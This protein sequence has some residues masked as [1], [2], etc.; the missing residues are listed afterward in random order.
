M[1]DL[2]FLNAENGFIQ[3]HDMVYRT[4]NGVDFEPYQ[5]ILDGIPTSDSI[6]YQ[7]V[8]VGFQFNGPIGVLRASYT[9][10]PQTQPWITRLWR[11]TDFGVTWIELNAMAP[12][13]IFNFLDE[14]HWFAADM[15]YYETMDGGETWDTCGVYLFSFPPYNGDCFKILDE[16]GRGLISMAYHFDF[17][18][19]MGCDQPI[20]ETTVLQ[21]VV[22]FDIQETYS[23]FLRF[24]DN[25][26]VVRTSID[27]GQT[28]L[29]GSE[30]LSGAWSIHFINDDRGWACGDDGKIWK[31]VSEGTSITEEA[32]LLQGVVLYPN[33]SQDILNISLELDQYPDRILIHD[34][35][36]REVID[37]RFVPN[38]DIRV[39][40]P[41][42][43]TITVLTDGLPKSARFVKID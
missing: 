14:Q 40:A 30:P 18:Y 21:Y 6:I 35:S 41:G 38:V 2:Y 12:Y 39:L 23:R 11:T 15:H 7:P 22:D 16:T 13:A 9:D 29:A 10:S 5:L 4:T 27:E 42:T 26:A 33:P 28:L 20:A 43:Y 31:Y 8:A 17:A 19:I 3:T 25:G 32:S 34:V 36:G 1:I 24:E 37:I